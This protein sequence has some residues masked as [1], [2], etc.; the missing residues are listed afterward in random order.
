M[1]NS[2]EEKWVMLGGVWD[3]NRMKKWI[4][5]IW[6]NIWMGDVVSHLVIWGKKM[7]DEY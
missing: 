5:D 1:K 6:I 2:Q 7:K 4:G 3:L